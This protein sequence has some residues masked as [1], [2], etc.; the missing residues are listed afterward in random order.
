MQLRSDGFGDG[1]A[2]PGRL[3]GAAVRS[4]ARGRVLAEARLSGTYTVNPDLGTPMGYL[5]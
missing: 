2:I 1:S 3:A 5:D 4:A